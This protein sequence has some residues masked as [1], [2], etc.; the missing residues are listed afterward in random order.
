MLGDGD[1]IAGVESVG[2]VGEYGDG[3]EGDGVLFA[4]DEGGGG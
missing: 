3:G 2:G 1:T 4:E